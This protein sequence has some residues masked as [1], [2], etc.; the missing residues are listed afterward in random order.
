M[1]LWA[2]KGKRRGTGLEKALFAIKSLIILNLQLCNTLIPVYLYISSDERENN[3]RRTWQK[4]KQ[5]V[6]GALY[7]LKRIITY[8]PCRSVSRV[9]ATVCFWAL[10][11][12]SSSG[13]G[14]VCL[15]RLDYLLL[16]FYSS[17]DALNL[18]PTPHCAYNI[19]IVIMQMPYTLCVWVVVPRISNL[20]VAFGGCGLV[21]LANCGGILYC[22]LIETIA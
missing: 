16:R 6:T 13:P 2:R 22:G 10:V 12:G 8:L 5:R 19:D 17:I 11:H 20:V 1:E 21:H 15:L 4:G 9:S 14:S 3:V 18:P 7:D